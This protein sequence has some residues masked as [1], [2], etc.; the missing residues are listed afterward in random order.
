MLSKH[1]NILCFF[2]FPLRFQYEIDEI[3]L[4]KD[5]LEMVIHQNNI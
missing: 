2:L 4:S 1:G 3:E 5:E